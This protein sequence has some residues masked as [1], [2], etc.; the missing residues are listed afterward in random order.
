[1]P[2]RAMKRPAVVPVA[3]VEILSPAAKRAADDAAAR[4][5]REAL[6]SRPAVE[7]AVTEPV[8]RKPR[9]RRAADVPSVAVSAAPVAQPMPAPVVPPMPAP[10]VP[11]VPVPEPPPAPLSFAEETARVLA[12]RAARYDRLSPG[13]PWIGVRVR[14][15]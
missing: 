14:A 11:P 7:P 5:A 10:V 4:A 15:A 2:R 6:A 9:A 3:T 1:M 8:L 13:Q 12:R